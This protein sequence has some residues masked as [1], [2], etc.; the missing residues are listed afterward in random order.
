MPDSATPNAAEHG[1]DRVRTFDREPEHS[2][3]SVDGAADA[4]Q[5]SRGSW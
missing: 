3:G 1:G 4:E 2:D 5:Q